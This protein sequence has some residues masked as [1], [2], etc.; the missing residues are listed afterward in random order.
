MDTSFT[1]QEKESQRFIFKLF[2]Q[3]VYRSAFFIV[4]DNHL[5]ED[6]AQETFIKLFQNIH[7]MEGQDHITKWLGVTT[8]NTAIDF[9]RKVK[10]TKETGLNEGTI[11]QTNYGQQSSNQVEK[12][13]EEKIMVEAIKEEI[14]KLPPEFQQVVLLRY[15]YDMKIKEI[16]EALDIK[17]NTVK[18]RLM[19]A[20]TR[21]RLQLDEL[22]EQ[23]DTGGEST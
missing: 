9:L 5:A 2:Y 8:T 14:N 18:S 3:R 15:E 10:R 1:Y 6:V 17:E 21:L 20:K 22:D 13:F 16:A 23:S 7:K 11:D 19:R 12:I 4:R